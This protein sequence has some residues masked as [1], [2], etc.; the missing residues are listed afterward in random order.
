MITKNIILNV[1]SEIAKTME[2]EKDYLIELDQQNGDGDLGISMSAGFNA[3]L[4][5]FKDDSGEDIGLGILKAAMTFNEKAPS[6]LGTILS[7]GLMAMGKTFKG[8]KVLTSEEFVS[9]FS[10]FNEEIM[11]KGG[12]KPGEKTIVDTLVPTEKYIRE[13]VGKISNTD[14]IKSAEQIAKESSDATR[15][16]KSVHGR[17]AYYAE[18]S[19]GVL[20]GG[21]Y[22]GYLIF[23][24]LN[25]FMIDGGKNERKKKIDFGCF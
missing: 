13:N 10:K 23:K 19:I 8:K 5:A 22:A 2:D 12:A 20:D 24:A 7:F 11:N 15:N 17:A 3:A 21:S 25:N 1:L 6:S 9:G 16:M 14:L 18:K 4:N